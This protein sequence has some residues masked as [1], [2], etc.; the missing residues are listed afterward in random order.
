[1]WCLR[2]HFA[3]DVYNTWYPGSLNYFDTK[4][5]KHPVQSGCIATT[6]T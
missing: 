4:F 2:G 5:G 6:Y 3:Q 1:M